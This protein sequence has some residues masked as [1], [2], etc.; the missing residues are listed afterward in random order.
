[1]ALI[2]TLFHAALQLEGT[3]YEDAVRNAISIGGDSDTIACIT[4][5]IA[6][7]M[8]GLP[9]EIAEAS[10]GYLTDDLV[11]VVDRFAIACN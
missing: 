8:F 3:D 4:G 5:G 1:M 7:V 9:D 10:R 6:E 11:E 2:A